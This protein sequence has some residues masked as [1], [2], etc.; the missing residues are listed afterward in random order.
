MHDVTGANRLQLRP[1]GVAAITA[2]VFLV[3]SFL[4]MR[5]E[6]TVA[7]ARTAAGGYVHASE[8]AGHHVG[9]DSDIHAQRDPQSDTGDCALLTSFHQAARAPLAAPAVVVLA[10]ASST[11]EAAAP[12]VELSALAVYR[13]APKTSPPATV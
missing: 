7:H 2:L 13:L 11:V 1:R 5:H 3:C 8:L 10:V 12:S 6:A 4:A 9:T